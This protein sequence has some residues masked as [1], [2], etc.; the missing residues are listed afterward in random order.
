MQESPLPSRRF[1]TSVS[2]PG[3]KAPAR[4]FP[5][6]VIIA[7]RSTIR[8][9][10]AADLG[11]ALGMGGLAVTSDA[12]TA[13]AGASGGRFAF[14]HDSQSMSSENE[15]TKNRISRCVSMCG[16]VSTA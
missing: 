8:G 3:Q 13:A 7:S 11:A 5:G 15:K 10:A 2:G 14:C 12:G 16:A 9:T 4:A 1:S 6:G